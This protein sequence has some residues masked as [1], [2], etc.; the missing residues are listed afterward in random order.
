MFFFPMVGIR[1]GLI[2]E[3][4][5]RVHAVNELTSEERDYRLLVTEESLINCSLSLVS[6][7]KFL[8]LSIMGLSSHIASS[9]EVITMNS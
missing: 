2:S 3:L 4:R 9:A 5:Q 6:S 1:P 8:P 7:G